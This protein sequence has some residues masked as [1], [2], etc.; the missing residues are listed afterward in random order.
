MDITKIFEGKALTDLTPAFYA[1]YYAQRAQ[2]SG[3]QL[4][5]TLVQGNERY[6]SGAPIP[7]NFAS[8]MEVLMNGQD[9]VV[10]ALACSD[11]RFKLDYM[12]DTNLGEIFTVLVAGGSSSKAAVG[13]FEY[14][15]APPSKLNQAPGSN[16]PRGLRGS[17][18]RS[19][20]SPGNG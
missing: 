7:K 19:Q 10:A 3:E 2:L 8:Q 16:R 5:A 9:P 4:E 17:E 18:C 1:D 20:G 11:S 12:F 14:G 15:G 13:S 6:T